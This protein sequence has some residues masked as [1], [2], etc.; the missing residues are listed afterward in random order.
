MNRIHNYK[1]NKQTKENKL[2]KIISPALRPR[3]TPNG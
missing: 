3:T 1:K 2:A